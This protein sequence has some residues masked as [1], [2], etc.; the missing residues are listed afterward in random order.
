MVSAYANRH[1]FEWTESDV[2]IRFGEEVFI[3]PAHDDT[4]I[5]EKVAVTVTWLAAKHLR[6]GLSELISS[7]ES[8]NGEIKLPKLPTVPGEDSTKPIAPPPTPKISK[9]K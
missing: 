3:T 1:Y 8:A 4:V 6:N 2:R 9:P 5:E 7:Y